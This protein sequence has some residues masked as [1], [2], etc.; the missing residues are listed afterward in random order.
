MKSQKLKTTDSW[1][2]DNGPIKYLPRILTKNGFTYT[3]V[4]CKGRSYIYEQEITE[5]VKYYEVFIAKVKP[6]RF[7]KGAMRP[8]K[9]AFPC[10][11]DFGKTAWSYRNLKDAIDKFL[12]INNIRKKKIMNIP[13]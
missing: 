8:A 12:E 2:Q 11:E 10:N 9:E 13:I 5:K 6:E 7:F 1:K 3:Q 4:L